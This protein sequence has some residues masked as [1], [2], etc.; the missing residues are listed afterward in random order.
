MT[1]IE[2]L[3]F[4]MPLGLG[5][6]NAYLLTGD[7]GQ[8]LI[9]TGATFHRAVLDAQLDE[10]APDLR[11][12]LLT[13]GDA[14]HAG[15]ASHLQRVRGV[16]VAMHAGDKAMVERGDMSAGRSKG[17]CILGPVPTWILG[18]RRPEYVVPD[19]LLEDGDTLAAYGVDA[20]ILHIPGH[21]SGSIAV[22]T[23][24]GDLFCGDLLENKHG[25]VLNSIMDDAS[26]ARASL[27]RLRSLPV[28]LVYPGHGEP[29]TLDQVILP[30][31]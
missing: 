3:H 20:T 17:G 8:V 18:Y 26:A 25:P 14:D 19:V 28:R 21:S 10:R 23:D 4:A 31:E 27:V 29:F 1:S 2:T 13:H 16:P 6:V 30:D 7:G 9:D 15:N 5:V 12:V 11:L 24:E 22:L